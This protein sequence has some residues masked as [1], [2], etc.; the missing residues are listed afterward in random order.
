[1]KWVK[2]DKNGP[3]SVDVGEHEASTAP[4][5]NQNVSSVL[6][7]EV[8]SSG[9]SGKQRISSLT[10]KPMDGFLDHPSG[11]CDEGL[12]RSDFG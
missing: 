6:V 12:A 3:A 9:R 7:R 11:F 2:N 5:H 10:K 8:L 4:S 1:M